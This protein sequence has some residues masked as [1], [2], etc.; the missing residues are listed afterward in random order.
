V[1]NRHIAVEAFGTHHGRTVVIVVK[2][3]A[4]A[5]HSAQDAHNGTT[6]SLAMCRTVCVCD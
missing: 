4:F 5:E 3:N 6:L 1:R 2:H